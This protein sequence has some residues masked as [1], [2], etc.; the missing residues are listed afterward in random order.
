VT[1]P[2]SVQDPDRD[3]GLQELKGLLK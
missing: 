2:E 1:V 3:R